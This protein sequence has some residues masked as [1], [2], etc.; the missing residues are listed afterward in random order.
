MPRARKKQF[1]GATL[2]NQHKTS[3]FTAA[4]GS[5]TKAYGDM[6][7]PFRVNEGHAGVVNFENADV[8]MSIL[9]TNRLAKD[10][11]AV[12]F[13]EHDGQILHEPTGRISKFFEMYGVYFIWLHVDTNILT[14]P[15]LHE[16]FVRRGN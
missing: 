7:I 5:L 1:K 11:N 14:H 2:K 16:G 3:G 8:E 15:N 10:Q 4:N 6:D 13:R 9:S 12:T